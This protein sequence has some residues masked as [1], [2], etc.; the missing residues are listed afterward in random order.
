MG[1]LH[2]VGWKINSMKSSLSGLLSVRRPIELVVLNCCVT[3][4]NDTP[5]ASKSSTSREMP[6][7]AAAPV[8]LA[9]STTLANTRMLSKRSTGLS[10]Y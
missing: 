6:S 7:R 3:E 2:L 8:K 10:D 4:T 5:C 1:L 9:L